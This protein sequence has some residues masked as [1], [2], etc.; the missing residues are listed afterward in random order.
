MPAA[1]QQS[2]AE[3]L[4]GLGAR[5][6]EIRGSV[7]QKEFASIVGIHE[8]TL[9][10]YESGE[11]VADAVFLRRLCAHFPSLN[12]EWLLLG[13]GTSTRDEEAML[14]GVH[15]PAE[16]G[17]GGRCHVD[18]RYSSIPMYCSATA[19]KCSMPPECTDSFDILA[20]NNEWIRR[21]LRAAPQ[22]L[23]LV[24]VNGE[25]ME[26]VLRPGDVVLVDLRDKHASLEAIY[27]LKM[28]GALLL[29]HVQR[30]PGGMIKVS[31]ENRAYESFTVKFDGVA[32]NQ[33]EIIG[34]VVWACR[35][36]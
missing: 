6:R 10:R 20:F 25:S 29:K 28:D 24:Q 1:G 34:R 27:A 22:D 4:N 18:D 32:E 26:G 17:D 21:S 9:K 36:Y 12:P 11:R 2:D 15:L 8:N 14:S 23:C 7:S 35:R 13:S 19:E 3:Y 31:S 30:L 16:G 33:L 5:F